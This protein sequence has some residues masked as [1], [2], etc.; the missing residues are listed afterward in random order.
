MLVFGWLDVVRSEIGD[1]P[2]I[3]ELIA[4]SPYV[5]VLVLSWWTWSGVERRLREA[6]SGVWS[7]LT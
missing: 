3:D 4:I 5:M 7:G 6:T 1:L 2:A